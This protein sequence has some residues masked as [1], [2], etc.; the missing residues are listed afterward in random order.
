MYLR[1]KYRHRRRT[2]LARS[3]WPAPALAVTL[4][5]PG[6]TRATTGP[7]LFADRLQ[8]G[9]GMYLRRGFT[10]TGGGDRTGPPPSAHIGGSYTTPPS[11]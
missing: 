4:L 1:G 5:R 9:Q 8:V 7:A 2:Q 11:L 10:A 3:A 6:R